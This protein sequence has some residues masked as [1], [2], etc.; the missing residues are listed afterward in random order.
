MFL[1]PFSGFRSPVSGF[2]CLSF[3]AVKPDSVPPEMNRDS[4]VISLEPACAGLALRSSEG[5]K[6]GAAYPWLSDGPSS[7]L[8]CLAPEGVFRAASVAAGAVGSYPTFSLSP[9][10]ARRS[11]AKEGYLF[12]VTLSV[13]TP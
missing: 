4:I 9:S 7:H 12:S 1:D 11:R 3:G 6:E 2:E 8:F 10:E 13:D 5:A